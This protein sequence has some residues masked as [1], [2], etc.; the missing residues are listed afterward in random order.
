MR[1]CFIL[2][3]LW[4]SGGV[5]VVIEY[6]NGLARR[7]HQVS[8]VFP[9][10]TQDA[11]VLPEIDSTV[12]LLSAPFALPDPQKAGLMRLARATWSLANTVPEVDWVIS[13]HTPTTVAGW[14]ASTLLRRGKSVWFNQD[15]LE[16]FT[17]RPI[18]T[19]LYRHALRWQ[20][21]ALVVS[22]HSKAEMLEFGPGPVFVVGD[23]LSQAEFFKPLPEV[24]L[25][26]MQRDFRP[27][28]FLGDMRPRKGLF[29]F[30]EAA[31]IVFQRVPGIKLW[32]VSKDKCDINPQ[33]PYEFFYRPPRDQLAHLYA[34]CDL[35]VSASWWESFGLP[36]LEALACGAP[37]VVTDS[38]GVRDFAKP[39]ENCL[40]TPP[41]NPTLLADAMVKVLTDSELAWRFRRA[42]PVTA[43]EFTWE[44]CIDR[45]E[46]ALDATRRC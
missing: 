13:T 42:G 29:D 3:T 9:D 17:D 12:R 7:G 44:R 39:G 28:L 23:G 26:H 35:F 5:R 21:A 27:I 14:I 1:I 25:G 40:M 15:Y 30:L 38:R 32:I 10:G 16:M 6:A 34:T 43:A 11:T 4:L 18:E 36:V 31:Q 22:S 45:F 19:W 24:D 2:S 46:T 33:V 8:L 37:M 20:R 41:Q